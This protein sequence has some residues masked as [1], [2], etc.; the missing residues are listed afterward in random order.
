[1]LLVGLLTTTWLALAAV[2]VSAVVRRN[3]ALAHHA[4]VGAT[5]CRHAQAPCGYAQENG[6]S[7]MVR[8]RT[9]RKA[10]S[11]VRRGTRHAIAREPHRR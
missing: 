3:R 8:Q 5:E 7:R 10:D 4:A 11:R 1:M 9:H 2:A 6:P